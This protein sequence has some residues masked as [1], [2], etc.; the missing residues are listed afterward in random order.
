VDHDLARS[1]DAQL[2]QLGERDE[3]KPA[4]RG[5]LESAITYAEVRARWSLMTV[6]E[7]ADQDARRTALHNVAIDALNRLSREA[8]AL[9]LGNE[10]RATLGDDRKRIGDFACWCALFRG[11]EFR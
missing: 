10:W 1:L 9:G 4:F 5:W 6:A 2:R 11:I 7:R 3:L 8:R